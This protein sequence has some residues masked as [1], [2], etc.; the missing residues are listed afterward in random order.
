MGAR[1]T[2]ILYEEPGIQ[3]TLTCRSAYS[4]P[5]ALLAVLRSSSRVQLAYRL[6]MHHIRKIGH[7]GKNGRTTGARG[8]R[9][10]TL[11]PRFFRRM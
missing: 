6:E 4:K 10:P 11:A 1:G 9:A 7:R 8:A 3:V 5:L 2:E